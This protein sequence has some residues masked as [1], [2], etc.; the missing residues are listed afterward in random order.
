MSG[1]LLSLGMALVAITAAQAAPVSVDEI[2]S[3]PD[4]F[5]GQPV[6]VSGTM[7]HFRE[8]VSPIRCAGAGAPGLAMTA[9]R[10]RL[11]HPQ[12]VVFVVRVPQI[13]EM[14]AVLEHHHLRP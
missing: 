9:G 4:C 1:A 7:S 3:N 8:Y 13:P 12:R 2:L 5:R 14:S 10:H 11:E 6:T